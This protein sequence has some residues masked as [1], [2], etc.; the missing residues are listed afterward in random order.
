M[1][2]F[3]FCIQRYQNIFQVETNKGEKET[4]AQKKAIRDTMIEAMKSYPTVDSEEIWKAV[5]SA[6]M[7]RKSGISDP[8]VV[9]KVVSAENS[10]KKSSGHAFEEMIKILG[11]ISL[12]EHGIRILLQKDLKALIQ[13]GG[14]SNEVRDISWLREQIG[15]S[16]FDLYITVKSD[17]KE[18]VYGCIQSKTSIRDRVTRDRE[19]SINAMN[20][21]FWSTAI[22]LDG[23]FLK[24]PKFIGMVNG[25]TPEHKVNGWHGLY[26]FS[27]KY[28]V[29]RI[30]ATDIDLDLFVDH[31]KEAADFWLTQRQWFDP[32]WRPQNNLESE[33]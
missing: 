21:F 27:D 11:N 5:Y 12:Q 29:D 10:W 3:E 23:S 8:E 18:F 9:R 17:D 33:S 16:V 28:S 26:V 14:I 31:A 32:G 13:S 25:D 24:L 6:H 20:A 1:N 19:P 22:C 2:F 15:S 4:F 7:D 30:Y